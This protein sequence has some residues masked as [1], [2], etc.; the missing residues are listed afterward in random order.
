MSLYIHKL[1]TI[2]FII[3][4]I[5][6]TASAGVGAPKCR[7]NASGSCP[8]GYWC[9]PGTASTINTAEGLPGICKQVLKDCTLADATSGK[10][11][12]C[13][14]DGKTYESECQRQSA[15]VHKKHDGKCSA[16]QININNS[17]KS[18][19]TILP[20]LSGPVPDGMMERVPEFEM[21]PPYLKAKVWAGGGC[22]DH[23]YTLHIALSPVKESNPPGLTAWL[24]LDKHGDICKGIIEG[25]IRFDLRKIKAHLP[26]D[27]HIQTLGKTQIIRV[28]PL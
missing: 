1:I 22:Q 10:S 6:F 24:S 5:F 23:L 14:H 18:K 27:L 11:P 17:I 2:L 25:T 19:I 8:D 7:T 3:S 21:A 4:I 12:V 9:D 28:P 20:Q 13:G 15:Q 16:Q 26:A